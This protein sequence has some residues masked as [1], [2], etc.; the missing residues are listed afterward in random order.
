MLRNGGGS[1]RLANGCVT[2]S[3]G[4]CLTGGGNCG[5][6]SSNGCGRVG[7]AGCGVELYASDGGSKRVILGSMD[8]VFVLA[9]ATS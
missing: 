4:S 1:V 5:D 8:V 9:Y 3:S 2:C 7:V 6:V